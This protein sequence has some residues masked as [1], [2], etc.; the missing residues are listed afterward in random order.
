MGKEKAHISTVVTGHTDSGQS[1][2]AEH[3]I[4]RW[5]GIDKLT[6]KKMEKEAAEM[7]KSS[8]KYA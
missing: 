5:G 4:Y 8:F 6:F 3:L 2:A 1:T 7:R